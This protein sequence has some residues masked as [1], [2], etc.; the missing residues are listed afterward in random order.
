MGFIN[1]EV[2]ILLYGHYS[3]GEQVPWELGVS[4]MS[5]NQRQSLK[6]AYRF[7]K[8]VKRLFWF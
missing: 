7:V 2:V 6:E 1:E 3:T 8:E 4:D 5:E